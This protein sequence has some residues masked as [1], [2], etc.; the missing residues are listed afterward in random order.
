MTRVEF[1]DPGARRRLVSAMRDNRAHR[2]R[3]AAL[4]AASLATFA[5]LLHGTFSGGFL[6]H[7]AV[8]P[9]ADVRRDAATV[10][11]QREVEPM[12][13]QLFVGVAALAAWSAPAHGVDRLVPEQY[14][15]IQAAHDAAADGDRIVLSPG[16]YPM[17]DWAISKAVTVVSA[18]G[19]LSTTV[20]AD[21]PGAVGRAF[22]IAG[23]TMKSEVRVVGI[24]FVGG[25]AAAVTAGNVAIERCRFVAAGGSGGFGGAL[26]LSGN[27]R[28]R[29]ERCSFE[30]CT[31]AGA[32]AIA[33]WSTELTAIDCVFR[34]NTANWSGGP[35]EGGAIHMLASPGTFDGCIFVGNT[36]A[37]GGAICRWWNN[38][39]V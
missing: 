22:S 12:R 18:D 26:S 4:A 14:P 11:L 10:A 39:A 32:G 24:T 15:T 23:P 16:T 38:P 19:C 9:S 2:S 30:Q 31:A 35:S 33:A 28:V 6:T 27:S 20:R 36:A 29:L 25:A 21:L 1:G 7:A 5:F 8:G 37:I 34:N 13:S 3:G 17:Q